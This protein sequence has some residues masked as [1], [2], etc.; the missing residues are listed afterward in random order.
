MYEKLGMLSLQIVS[1]N[2]VAFQNIC[3]HVFG[4]SNDDLTL[5][6]YMGCQSGQN[7]TS[8]LLSNFFL[9]QA[10]LCSNILISYLYMGA[11]IY[12]YIGAPV[13]I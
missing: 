2:N 7:A 13:C 4:T 11:P 5:L 8:A 12:L 10:C 1:G 6:C 9:I 3:G